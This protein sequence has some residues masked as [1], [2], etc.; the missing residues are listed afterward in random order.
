[1]VGSVL[2]VAGLVCYLARVRRLGDRKFWTFHAPWAL[3]H[4]AVIFISLSPAQRYY[5]IIFPLLLV[6]LLRG[7]LELRPPWN[8]SALAFPALLLY[9]AVPLAIEN[10]CHGPP[11]MRLAHYL[12]ELYPL[13]QRG[14]VVLLFQNVRRHV[15]WY[16]PGFVSYREIPRPAELPQLVAGAAAVYTDDVRVPLPPGW[17]RV[18]LIAFKR[19]GLIYWKH[20]SLELYLGDR[21]DH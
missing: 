7:V 19:S 3:T 15:E 2:A 9:I 5:L 14:S 1:V 12:G 17:S 13:P 10:H 20:H 4:I 16:A 6:A 11:A 18:P 21:H 8:W